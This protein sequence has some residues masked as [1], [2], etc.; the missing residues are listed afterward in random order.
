MEKT[1]LSS[2]KMPHR[3]VLHRITSVNWLGK[4]ALL[5][6]IAHLFIV[7][8]LYTGISKFMEFDLFQE[9]LI[10]SPVLRPVALLVSWSIPIV[11]FCIALMLFVPRTRLYGLYSSFI[12]MVVF[13]VYVSII[14]I[15][16]KELPCSCGGIVEALSWKGH[17][18]FN[19]IFT[20]LALVGIRLYKKQFETRSKAN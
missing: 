6:I 20:V 12:I 4:S 13:T 17:L 11:E 1:T 9:Q 2:A 18:V 5:E 19:L 7:L 15:I 3:S 14:L 16:D 10:E 8:Y